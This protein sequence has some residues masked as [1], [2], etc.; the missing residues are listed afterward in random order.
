MKLENKDNKFEYAS[1]V[2]TNS[3]LIVENI[4][5]SAISLGLSLDL[6]KKYM[7]K[8]DLLIRTDNE[9]ILNM[10]ERFEEFEEEP[11]EVTWIFPDVIYPKDNV[12]QNKDEEIEELVERSRKKEIMLQIKS[13][14]F[15]D[16]DNFT[17]LFKFTEIN[18]NS[19]K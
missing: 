9:I 11:K 14:K 5:S 13:I 2:L 8:L 12:H 4:S 15:N 17:F 19:Q 18:T 1:Y 7:V 16:N 3:D 10:Y 6:L